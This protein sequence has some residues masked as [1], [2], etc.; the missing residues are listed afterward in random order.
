MK[1]QTKYGAITVLVLA[2]IFP[3]NCAPAPTDWSKFR[4]RV[5]VAEISDAPCHKTVV[6]SDVSPNINI[7]FSGSRLVVASLSHFG[8]WSDNIGAN[9]FAGFRVFKI[10]IGTEINSRKP[11]N[12]FGWQSP[13]I[14]DADMS[15][16]V[17]AVKRVDT[18]RFYSQISALVRSRIDNLKAANNGEYNCENCDYESRIGSNSVMRA[19]SETRSDGDD[20]T[21][22]RVFLGL[23]FLTLGCLG[24]VL[25]FFIGR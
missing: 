23:V 17:T 2:S 13:N 15:D 21:N 25:A 20:D 11:H 18:A 1:S 22:G 4:T 3:A 12:F 6:I 24:L 9:S 16:H 8:T 10:L 7:A 5:A 19:S 14:F